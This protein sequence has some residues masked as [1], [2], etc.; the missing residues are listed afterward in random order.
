MP[1]PGCNDVPPGHIHT[2]QCPIPARVWSGEPPCPPNSVP[3]SGNG[4]A[5]SKEHA[6][7]SGDHQEAPGVFQTTRHP[8]HLPLQPPAMPPLYTADRKQCT[9][10]PAAVKPAGVPFHMP[11]PHVRPLSFLPRGEG[12][13]CPMGHAPYPGDLQMVPRDF[14]L[15]R[16]S[17]PPHRRPPEEL[18]PVGTAYRQRSKHQPL[19]I[20]LGHQSA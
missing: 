5:C 16:T 12:A 1:W 9:K 17:Q 7:T 3:T 11:E 6:S 18:P 20:Q 19:K 10:S 2:S 4:G 8:V 14:G 13:A 15:R